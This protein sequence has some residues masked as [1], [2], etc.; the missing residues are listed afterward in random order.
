M[1]VSKVVSRRA[2]SGSLS[3]LLREPIVNGATQ[4]VAR[5]LFVD[6][7]SPR[8]G[9]EI[10]LKD[11]IKVQ[12]VRS[13]NKVKFA[14]VLVTGVAVVGV[15]VACSPKVECEGFFSYLWKTSNEAV[16]VSVLVA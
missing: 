5:R 10:L 15:T 12:T 7:Q 2:L 6:L 11:D 1:A 3:G 13:S 4:K 8:Q 16:I 14:E 9:F